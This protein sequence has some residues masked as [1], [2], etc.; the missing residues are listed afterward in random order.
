[1]IYRF[2]SI[3]TAILLSL[4]GCSQKS[5]RVIKEKQRPFDV[6]QLHEP[7]PIWEARSDYGNPPSYEVSGE[8]YRVLANGDNYKERGVASWYGPNFHGKFTSNREVYD[9]YKLSAAHKT[10]P[11]PTYVRVTNL[12]NSLSVVLRVNDRG[13]FK[14]DRIIDLSYAAALKLDMIEQGTSQ[15]EVEVLRPEN[16]LHAPDSTTRPTEIYVQTGAFSSLD[17]AKLQQIML[18]NKGFGQVVLRPI[19]KGQLRLQR[20]RIGPVATVELADAMLDALKLAGISSP[21][22]VLE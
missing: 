8:R 14:S 6:N 7:T 10:L 3:T 21:R 11:I 9:M 12:E 20:V 19:E 18:K 13:P 22:V 1:M 15:V 16:P 2:A 4:S 5:E 17:N